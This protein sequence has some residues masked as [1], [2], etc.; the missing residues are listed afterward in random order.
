M[1]GTLLESTAAFPFVILI[2]FAYGG[3]YG[4]AP[5]VEARHA[6]LP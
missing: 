2:A 6:T 1:H 5:I 3:E 4:A